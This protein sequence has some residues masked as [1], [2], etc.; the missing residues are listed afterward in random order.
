MRT[1]S[2]GRA[3]TR[4]RT[5]I[6][7]VTAAALVGAGTVLPVGAD[8]TAL[9]L[10]LTNSGTLSIDAPA[11]ASATT[12]VTSTSGITATI[13]VNGIVITD[14][15][16]LP[17][18][19]TATASATDLTNGSDT[20]SNAGMIWLS[21]SATTG[22]GSPAPGVLG[23]GGA[24]NGTAIVAIGLG[25]G[26]GANSYTVNGTITVPITGKAPG[27]YTGTLTTSIN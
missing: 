2:P 4:R 14:A 3:A 18:V 7:L 5:S 9:T 21:T 24:L 16:T 26:L 15:R 17:G 11:A 10:S 1:Y 22:G 13:P 8:T 12:D 25:L 19:F 23:A 6:A 27:E 20:I